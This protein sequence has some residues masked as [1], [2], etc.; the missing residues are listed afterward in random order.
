M[1]AAAARAF[2]LS[3]VRVP[4][5]LLPVSMRA[6]LAPAD[7]EGLVLC[8]VSVSRGKISAVHNVGSASWDVTVAKVDC[9]G[10]LLAACWTNAHTHLVKTHAHPRTRNP[11]GSISDALSSEVVDQPR[12][13]AC[14]CCRPT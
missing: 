10:S 3:K 5:A 1:A 9:A 8:D 7:S 13:A 11:T 12:W 2:I 4:R 14:K 6:Q